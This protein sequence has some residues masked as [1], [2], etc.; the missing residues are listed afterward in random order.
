MS[1][2]VSSGRHAA[3]VP[4]A[5]EAASVVLHEERLSTSLIRRPVERIRVERYVVTEQQT[6]T[7]EVRREEV[8]VTREPIDVASEGE[9]AD[10]APA[11]RARDFLMT[12]NREEILFSKRIVPSEL[13][14]VRVGDVVENHTVTETLGREQLDLIASP[15][16]APPRG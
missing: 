12:L 16:P 1:T 2:N 3:P 6:F 4:E 9:P 13:V 10:V 15:S 8:R 11:P 14:R 5:D 7:V